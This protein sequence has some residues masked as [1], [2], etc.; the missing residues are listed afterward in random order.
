MSDRATLPVLILQDIASFFKLR[1]HAK[2]IKLTIRRLQWYDTIQPS[3]E[4]RND[5]TDLVLPQDL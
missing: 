3:G 2:L 5:N 1:P 4:M